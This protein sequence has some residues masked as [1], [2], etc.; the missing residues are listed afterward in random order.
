MGA[1]SLVILVGAL[2]VLTM[3][4][5]AGFPWP[6]PVIVTCGVPGPCCLLLIF[7]R[8]SEGVWPFLFLF[9]ILTLASTNFVLWI[10]F[11]LAS[12]TVFCFCDNFCRASNPC[13]LP[14]PVTLNCGDAPFLGPGLGLVPIVLW[15]F[16]R[17]PRPRI[18][19]FPRPLVLE[20]NGNRCNHSTSI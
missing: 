8:A 17:P 2:V 10:I 20:I 16:P 19:A 13:T 9:C 4:E 3:P 14:N 12:V 5:A 11:S 18:P 6:N 1:A 15:M 7:S